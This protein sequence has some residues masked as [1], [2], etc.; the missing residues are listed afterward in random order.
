MQPESVFALGLSGRFGGV[1]VSSTKPTPHQIDVLLAYDDAGAY[2]GGTTEF[3]DIWTAMG[4][5]T[6]INSSLQMRNFDRGVD[7]LTRMGLVRL[8]DETYPELT[9][10]GRAWVAAYR[11]ARKAGGK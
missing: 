2:E 5:E 7:A 8:V 4:W 1:A 10:D 6:R 9:A 3:G 11:A